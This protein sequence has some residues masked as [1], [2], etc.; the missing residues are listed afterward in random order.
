MP[1]SSPGV[2]SRLRDL[3]LRFIRQGVLAEVDAVLKY[4]FPSAVAEIADVDKIVKDLVWG[5]I[6]IPNYLVPLV[7]S[8]LMQRQ[9]RIRQLG[10]SYLVYPSAGYGRFEHALGCCHVMSQVLGSID[11][12]THDQ[13][14][15]NR[16]A[17]PR[18]KQLLIGALLHD[19]GHMPF[20][21]ASEECLEQFW[22]KLRIGRLTVDNLVMEVCDAL[23]KRL[24]L[25]EVLSVLVVMSSRLH[26]FM[27]AVAPISQSRAIDFFLEIAAFI[28]GARLSDSDLAYSQL[29]SGPLDVDR[30]DYMIRDARVSGVPVSVDVPR[31]L[32]RC[33]FV[34]V[35]TKNLPATMQGPS[36]D[37]LLFVTDLSGANA[38][39]ELAVSRFL[40]NDRIYNH[41][42]TQAAQ[43]ILTDLLQ[44]TFTRRMFGS[45]LLQFWAMT[46]ESFLELATRH[47]DTRQL[48]ERLLYRELP[49]RAAVL[50]SR[51]IKRPVSALTPD[52]PVGDDGGFEVTT[53]DIHGDT[54][55]NTLRQA[56]NDLLETIDETFRVP[57]KRESLRRLIV[58]RATEIA[59]LLPDR[60]RE[61]LKL[62]CLRH[63]PQNPFTTVGDA[64]VI[65]QDLSVTKLKQHMPLAQWSAAFDLNKKFGYVYCQ[66]GWE[67]PVN[68]ATELVL[69]ERYLVR[70][71]GLEL[72]FQLTSG[73]A[74]RA[75]LSYDRMTELKIELDGSSVFRGARGLRPIV[76]KTAR[77]DKLADKFKLFQG[78][79]GWSV[80][81]ES[82]VAFIKQF[83]VRLQDSICLLLERVELLDR[84]ALT[85]SIGRQLKQFGLQYAGRIEV[86][87]LTPNSG[88]L[89]RMLGEADLSRGLGHRFVFQ[90]SIESIRP[91]ENGIALVDDLVASGSQALTQLQAIIG[92]PKV[93][94]QDPREVNIFRP[95]LGASQIDSLKNRPVR[96]I[97]AY[98]NRTGQ[99][100]VVDG[101]ERL[102]LK[103]FDLSI[104]QEIERVDL[105]RNYGRELTQFL[106]KVGRE[107]LGSWRRNSGSSRNDRDALG[108]SGIS[109]LVTSMF[110]VPT[111][112]PP[113]LWCPGRVDR[114]PWIPLFIRRGYQSS[115]TFA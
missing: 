74:T 61:P 53:T 14:G 38:L 79:D 41:Q 21:H 4:L 88:N 98:G 18:R 84:I 106:K 8:R 15:A 95:K 71:K 5:I 68:L 45:N 114:L 72:R 66:R 91:S 47:R 31:L 23:D 58:K 109:S 17:E 9:R 26:R 6:N 69:Y 24:R 96:A 10:V 99:T 44:V 101:A 115:A 63:R 83:P 100:L 29:L 22:T 76:V 113:A 111:S 39:E 54:W 20:S 48:A 92:L 40:L 33:Q 81:L 70:Q 60:P 27:T 56:T 51:L 86:V 12:R 57:R 103:N 108:Y 105:E 42:K 59:R 87:G 75:K 78:G 67:Y 28:A 110:N 11:A 102:G 3:R 7:D 37:A 90:K 104:E 35:P 25:A 36:A 97:Y 82:L 62:L 52:G 34:R 49:N 46:D 50:G 65:D 80:S 85:R 112:L 94:W 13:P 32:A 55:T 1:S 89:V 30:L 19:I 77:L 107:V 2:L 16:P 73:A 43:A 64:V 93:E